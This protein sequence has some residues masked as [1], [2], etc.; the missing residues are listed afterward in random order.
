MPIKH[1]AHQQEP[2]I[3]SAPNYMIL[4]PSYRLLKFRTLVCS[5]SFHLA[6]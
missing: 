6:Q 3:D 5:T 2:E 1:L 4:T